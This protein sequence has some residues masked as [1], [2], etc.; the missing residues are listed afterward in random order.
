MVLH[1]VLAGAARTFLLNDMGDELVDAAA[2]CEPVGA[3]NALMRPRPA[4]GPVGGHR[5]GRHPAAR[6]TQAERI[7]Q[8]RVA[9]RRIRSNLRT[10]RLLLDPAWG[11][12]LRAELAWYGDRLGQARDLHIMRDVV[13]VTGPTVI[14]PEDMARLDVGGRRRGWPRRWP[15]S[16]PSAAGPAGSS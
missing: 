6:T 4:V 16:P 5:A 2:A 12:S 15:T 3:F 10:F 8:S 11:T 9:L 14:D 7:H 13:T 1:R